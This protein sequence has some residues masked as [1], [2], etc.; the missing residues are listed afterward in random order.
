MP[1]PQHPAASRIARYRR[2]HIAELVAAVLLMAK[3]YRILA[4]RWR[5]PYGE[6]DLIARRSSRQQASCRTVPPWRS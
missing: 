1:T 4:R 6:I 5:S 3:G 2:G